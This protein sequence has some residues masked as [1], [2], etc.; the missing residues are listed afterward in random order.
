MFNLF[1]KK[2]P[3]NSD[4]DT[5]KSRSASLV[6]TIKEDGS[7]TATFSLSS[8]DADTA[9]LFS[10]MLVEI[11]T[12]EVYLETLAIVRDRLIEEDREDLAELIFINIAS[13][14]VLESLVDG[15]GGSD[16]PHIKPS[17]MF[18]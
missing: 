16:E 5:D 1:K 3:K 2:K 6:Y 18:N 11:G 7:L 15:E 8:I 13:S 10:Q 14:K 17:D 12:A 9:E 4:G